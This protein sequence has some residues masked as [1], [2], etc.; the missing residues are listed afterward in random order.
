MTVQ[1]LE[2]Y[3]QT[4]LRV[5]LPTFWGPNLP[6]MTLK[7]EITYNNG[8]QSTALTKTMPYKTYCKIVKTVCVSVM[9]R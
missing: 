8:D 3:M 4:H 7:Y 5:G 2:E 1:D 6:T 9:F